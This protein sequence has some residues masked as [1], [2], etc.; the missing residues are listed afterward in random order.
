MMY[1]NQSKKIKSDMNPQYIRYASDAYPICPIVF[2][3]HTQPTNITTLFH[4][5]KLTPSLSRGYR[6][7]V[8]FGV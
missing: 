1:F 2:Y 7:G 3:K 5:P 8:S 6:A 4:T